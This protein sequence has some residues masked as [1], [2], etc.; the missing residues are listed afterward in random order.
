MPLPKPR[1]GQTKEKWLQ[2][3][4]GNATMNSEYTDS[5]QRYAICL[6]QWNRRKKSIELGQEVSTDED[7][8]E[9]K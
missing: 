3:C 5:A 9:T 1:K 4:M 6:S 8:D 7:I 2:S